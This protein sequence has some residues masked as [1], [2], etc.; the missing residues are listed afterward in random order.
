[1][2]LTI[3]SE[4]SESTVVNLHRAIVWS[5]LDI[6]R[7]ATISQEDRSSIPESW[8]LSASQT[9]IEP[10]LVLQL[11]RRAYLLPLALDARNVAEVHALCKT[12]AFAGAAQDCLDFV[13]RLNQPDDVVHV[14]NSATSPEVLVCCVSALARMQAQHVSGVDLK[15][16]MLLYTHRLVAVVCG[17]D[18]AV[19]FRRWI[20]V[21]GDGLM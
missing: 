10:D 6:S 9:Q 15:I 11:L 21:V 13:S 3:P 18:L 17:A 12:V 19:D 7:I 14:Y 20:E 4:N 16:I 2:T 1:M 8:L 5:S